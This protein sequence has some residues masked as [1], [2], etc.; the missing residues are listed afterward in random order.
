[1][2]DQLAASLD[3]ILV[4]VDEVLEGS[5][6]L[7]YFLGG[8]AV[9]ELG[10]KLGLL[11]KEFDNFLVLV[12][13]LADVIGGE[14]IEESFLSL[15]VHQVD[16]A[17]DVVDAGR[18]VGN[19]T[20][21]EF[22]GASSSAFSILNHNHE[23]GSLVLIVEV[24]THVT[25][26]FHAIDIHLA[27]MDTALQFVHGSLGLVLLGAEVVHLA[28]VGV[29]GVDK[30]VKLVFV[31]IEEIIESLLGSSD[32]VRHA[33]ELA[34]VDVCKSLVVLA[35]HAYGESLHAELVKLFDDFHTV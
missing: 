31:K 2:F 26:D 7:R 9:S 33:F 8:R 18:P 21:S 24:D 10:G 11:L 16:V 28:G 13:D 27:V 19:G 12:F 17:L 22:L 4:L 29:N 23:S 25:F 14:G 3:A 1:M 30:L 5:L 15:G 34:I 32:G 35:A 6:E 20:V